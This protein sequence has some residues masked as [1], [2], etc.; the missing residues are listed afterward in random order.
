MESASPTEADHS[1]TR[2]ILVADDNAAAADTLAELLSLYGNEVRWSTT[3]R[4]L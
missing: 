1:S 3:A 4:P 2:R